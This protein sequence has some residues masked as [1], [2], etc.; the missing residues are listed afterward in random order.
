[1]YTE[2]LRMSPKLMALL[3]LP[4]ACTIAVLGALLLLVPLPLAGRLPIVGAMFVETTVGILLLTFLS[5]IRVAIDD[6]A[7]TIAF[8]LFLVKR[9]PLARIVSC[10]PSDA[11]VW[12][13]AYRYRG[14]SYR[15]RTSGGRAVLLTL[16]NGAQVAFG[17]R[18]PDAVCEELRAHRP[19]IARAAGF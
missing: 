13:M 14:T 6:R 5:R 15:T 9:I 12:G 1:M 2:E 19:E 18:H 10:A 16:T 7:L 8:R 4:F 17:T 11:R 3:A